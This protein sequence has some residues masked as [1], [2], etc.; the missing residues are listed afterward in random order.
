MRGGATVLCCDEGPAERVLEHAAD[1]G[2]GGNGEMAGYIQRSVDGEGDAELVSK[3]SVGA[4]AIVGDQRSVR[5][6]FE[7]VQKYYSAGV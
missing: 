3:Y 6:V 4:A 2:G 5:P 7:S 1:G